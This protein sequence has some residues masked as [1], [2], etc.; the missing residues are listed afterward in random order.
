MLEHF[1]INNS[2][3]SYP[4]LIKFVK[5]QINEYE[6]MEQGIKD[7][8]LYY[9]LHDPDALNDISMIQD[10]MDEWKWFLEE[11]L[12]DELKINALTI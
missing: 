4:K 10:K 2:M 1:A 8:A 11:I 9:V 5:H 7:N 12:E 3:L 6:K